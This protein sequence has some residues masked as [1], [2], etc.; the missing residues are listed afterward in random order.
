MPEQYYPQKPYQGQNTG[1][2]FSTNMAQQQQQAQAYSQQQ[3]AWRRYYQQQQQMYGQIPA[4]AQMT[5]RQQQYGQQIQTANAQPKNYNR[6]IKNKSRLAVIAIATL[7]GLMFIGALTYFMLPKQQEAIQ[8]KPAREEA[9]AVI[10]LSG[11]QEM[12]KSDVAIDEIKF[13]SDIDENF[14]CYEDQD[15]TFNIG[16][17]VY[18]YVRI[19]GFSQVKRDEGNLIGIKEDVETL[20]PE[21]IS[22]YQLSGTAQNLAD[23]ITEGQN[24]LHLKNRLRIPADLTAGAYTL[25]I[26]IVDKITGKEVRKEKGF[27]IE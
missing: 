17:S 12:L 10:P 1:Q 15:N 9:P 11:G 13:C 22:V 26:S 8:E 16:S 5:Q 6:Q 19:R 20:D 2:T 4:Q 3:E 7:F 14:Y 18:L 25:K 27:W 23:F 24:Y 21:G